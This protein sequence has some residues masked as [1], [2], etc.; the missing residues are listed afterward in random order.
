MWGIK[1]GRLGRK[2]FQTNYI[3]GWKKEEEEEAK[4]REK[5]K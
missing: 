2:L 3:K 4:Q 1:W 5:A